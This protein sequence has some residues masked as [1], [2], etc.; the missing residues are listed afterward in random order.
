MHKR[1][2]YSST[3]SFRRLAKV[4]CI[5]CTMLCRS[6]YIIAYLPSLQCHKTLLTYLGCHIRT[7][8]LT[9]L[10]IGV[11]SL[12]LS[13]TSL[14]AVFNPNFVSYSTKNH[15][16]SSQYFEKLSNVCLVGSQYLECFLIPNVYIFSLK[17]ITVSTQPCQPSGVQV[18]GPGPGFPVLCY[19]SA[20]S[21][22]RQVGSQQPYNYKGF[23]NIELQK[24]HKCMQ[25]IYWFLGNNVICC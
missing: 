7:A 21:A 11:Q 16:R 19:Y 9:E 10:Y 23:N 8:T 6:S 13:D 22:G 24:M 14:S 15:L 2:D 1:Y 12:L 17:N 3:S 5:A 18:N 4:H 20:N 25:D